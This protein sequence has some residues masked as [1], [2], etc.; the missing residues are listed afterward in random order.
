MMSEMRI[1][2]ETC[3][4]SLDELEPSRFGVSTVHMHA[5]WRAPAPFASLAVR[6]DDVTAGVSQREK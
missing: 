5:S 6:A 2:I 4:D 1:M 3:A